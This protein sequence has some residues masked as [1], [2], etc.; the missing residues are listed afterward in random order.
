MRRIAWA[1]AVALALAG[2]AFAQDEAPPSR[3]G[4]V[5]FRMPSG[6]QRSEMPECTLL[7]PADP[8]TRTYAICI[9]PAAEAKATVADALAADLEVV[10]RSYRVQPA[11]A[12]SVQKHPAGYDGAVRGYFLAGAD[13]KVLAT[14]VYVLQ[15]GT[16]SVAIEFLADRPENLDAKAMSDFVVACRLAHAQVVVAGEPA[17]TLYDLEETIDCVQWLL[18]APFTAEQ[19]GVFH[20]EIVDGWKKKDTE[21]I[22]GVAQ[23]LQ[24]RAELAKLP[25]EKQDVVRKA[26]EKDLVAALRQET[27]R[28]SKLALEVYDASHRPIAGGEPPL[29]R[30]QADCA[31]ELFYFFAGQLEG[32][33]A[34]PTAADK[35]EW[36]KRLAAGWEKLDVKVRRAFE[37]MPLTWSATR[38]GWDEMKEAERTELKQ[39]FAQLDIV[40]EMRGAFAKVKSDA[41]ASADAAA[42]QA[43]LTSNYRVTSTLLKTGF[44]STMMQMAAMRN[45]TDSYNRWSYRPR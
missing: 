30:Q 18:D 37:V 17:L 14:Y 38:A 12:L 43:K 26:T 25:P 40:K 21:T 5:L 23:I 33:Q 27:D 44:D 39:G 19:R 9:R 41:G 45:M 36:A 31:L 4:T 16:K 6:W 42:L 1:V 20:D 32:M 11:S 15:A 13:G 34:R 7:T 28:S 3:A 2:A 24:L 8:A 35:E 29:T 22:Q 10:G